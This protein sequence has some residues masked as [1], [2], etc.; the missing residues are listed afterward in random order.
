MGGT[1]EQELERLLTGKVDN[2]E[3]KGSFPDV[4]RELII[5]HINSIFNTIFPGCWCEGVFV[6][7]DSNSYLV[8]DLHPCG[9]NPPSSVSIRVLDFGD[10]FRILRV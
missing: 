7:K 4:T 2:I 3:L 8:Y 9:V 10:K 6:N 5:D 1:S